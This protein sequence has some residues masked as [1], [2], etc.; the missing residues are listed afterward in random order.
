MLYYFYSPSYFISNESSEINKSLTLIN[1]F[2]IGIKP[3][4]V[5]TEKKTYISQNIDF[6]SLL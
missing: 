1:Y 3:K 5:P 4:Q 2:L 6:Y